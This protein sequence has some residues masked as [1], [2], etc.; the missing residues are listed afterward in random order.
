M[1]MAG[2]PERPWGRDSSPPNNFVPPPHYGVQ[3][4]SSG[5]APA[6]FVALPHLDADE[7]AQMP[8]R[9]SATSKRICAAANACFLVPAFRRSTGPRSLVEST[10]TNCLPKAVTSPLLQNGGTSSS[11]AAAV[12]I[13]PAM[14]FGKAIRYAESG[15]PAAVWG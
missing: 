12:D 4:E 5:L 6:L 1:L 10:A 9:R 13:D 14:R 7:L 2:S 15:K 11:T 8:I 3:S